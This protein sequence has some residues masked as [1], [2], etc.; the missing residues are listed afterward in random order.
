M[1][2]GTRALARRKR[3]RYREDNPSRQVLRFELDFFR[4]LPGPGFF[5][6]IRNVT[7]SSNLLQ[8]ISNAPVA[9]QTGSDR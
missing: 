2:Y 5:D 7:F 8:W 3:R 6:V 9:V 4:N 1:L